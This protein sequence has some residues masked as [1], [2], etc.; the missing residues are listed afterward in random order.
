MTR[1]M[2]REGVAPPPYS[3][4]PGVQ[5]NRGGKRRTFETGIRQSHARNVGGGRGA[6]GLSAPRL[7][8]ALAGLR[9]GIHCLTP[10]GLTR[11]GRRKDRVGEVCVSPPLAKP[12]FCVTI[13]I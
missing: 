8:T 5:R 9:P 12:H 6:E 13:G 3:S 10:T 7:L 11:L 4:V 1:S 2:L